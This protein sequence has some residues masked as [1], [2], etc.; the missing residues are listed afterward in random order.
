MLWRT[1]L[2]VN[3]RCIPAWGGWCGRVWQA[4]KVSF[5]PLQEIFIWALYVGYLFL[6]LKSYF[7]SLKIF[8]SVL[9]KVLLCLHLGVL[10]FCPFCKIFSF[11]HSHGSALQFYGLLDQHECFFLVVGD[12]NHILSLHLIINYLAPIEK[13]YILSNNFHT[14][15][16]WL[17]FYP[18]CTLQKC[19][20]I[21]LQLH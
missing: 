17:S 2:L 9:F 19:I 10:L 5:F 18:S 7:H 16:F 12:M 6:F 14:Y 8:I 15:T 13:V 20:L 21:L 4:V 11:L 1:L 3:S